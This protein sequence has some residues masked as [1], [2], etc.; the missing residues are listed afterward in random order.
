MP[1]FDQLHNAHT[2]TELFI[3][4]CSLTRTPTY[5]P[6][7][8]ELASVQRADGLALELT[9]RLGIKQRVSPHEV[10]L[11]WVATH[12][13]T[14]AVDGSLLWQMR[15]QPPLTGLEAILTRLDQ[16]RES[17]DYP[18]LAERGLDEHA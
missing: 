17:L 11:S 13:F 1:G 10:Y 6:L 15:D 12:V 16:L 7:R 5:R 18:L 14:L 9:I 4:L 3:L 2:E 8:A